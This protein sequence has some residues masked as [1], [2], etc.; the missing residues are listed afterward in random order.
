MTTSIRLHIQLTAAAENA[1]R[2][3][4]FALYKIHDYN[5]L[6]N[7]VWIVAGVFNVGIVAGVF[8]R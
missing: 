7:S 1:I 2:I 8:S 5:C 3:N 4:I 6:V